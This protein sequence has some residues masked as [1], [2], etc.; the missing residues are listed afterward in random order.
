MMGTR[1]FTTQ[2]KI[3]T[4]YYP[5]WK[6]TIDGKEVEAT[7]TNYGIISLQVP[8]KSAS[9]ELNFVEPPIVLASIWISLI[10]WLLATGIFIFYFVRK[11]KAY[12]TYR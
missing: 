3:S 9:I 10:F 11:V 4:F 8:T 5:H 7:A 12:G 6:A 2:L 1:W